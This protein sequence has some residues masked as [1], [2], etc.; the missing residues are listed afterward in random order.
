MIINPAYCVGEMEE[1]NKAQFDFKTSLDVYD[2]HSFENS[3][4]KSEKDEI[5]MEGMLALQKEGITTIKHPYYETT[6]SS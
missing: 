4:M 2:C 3:K 5:Y 1:F 6:G